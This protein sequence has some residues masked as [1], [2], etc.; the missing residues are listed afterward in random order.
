MADVLRNRCFTVNFVKFSKLHF[1][2]SSQWF[3][4]F[5]SFIAKQ[6]WNLVFYFTKFKIWCFIWLQRRSFPVKFAKS[7]R[8]HFY[9]IPTVVASVLYR[10]PP[11]N[12]F[13]LRC[14]SF[15]SKCIE[16]TIHNS[17]RKKILAKPWKFIY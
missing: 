10:T 14:S 4:I 15:V 8:T 6:P 1:F 11:G 16:A 5:S 12:C 17:S 7:L 2:R 13:S 3:T 9:R